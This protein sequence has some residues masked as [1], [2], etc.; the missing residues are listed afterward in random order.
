MA[1]WEACLS[2]QFTSKTYSLYKLK[3][4]QMID[5][6]GRE[7]NYECCPWHWDA[8]FCYSLAD[9][10]HKSIHPCT[11]PVYVCSP[12]S[13]RHQSVNFLWDFDNINQ[14]WFYQRCHEKKQTAIRHLRL[15]VMITL[16]QMNETKDSEIP[17]KVIW[18]EAPGIKPKP[19]SLLR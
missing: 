15:T 16:D 9:S 1:L 18:C 19:I 5:R 2:P 6:K 12:L 11:I 4:W 14:V 7:K 3:G 13:N 8:C 17:G 10:V